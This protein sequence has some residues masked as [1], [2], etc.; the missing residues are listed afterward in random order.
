M[1]TL[2]VHAY[3]WSHDDGGTNRGRVNL[4]RVELECLEVLAQLLGHC[5]YM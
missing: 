1:S 5:V 2:G 3:V 4:P